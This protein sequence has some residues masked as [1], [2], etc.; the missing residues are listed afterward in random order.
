[1]IELPFCAGFELGSF[2]APS[3]VF[4]QPYAKNRWFG[5]LFMVSSV[6]AFSERIWC[7]GTLI[8]YHMYLFWLTRYDVIAYAT[9]VSI[10]HH[11]TYFLKFIS[12]AIIRYKYV[13]LEPSVK[14]YK[15][16]QCYG[17]LS[18]ISINVS[19]RKTVSLKNFDGYF[20]ILI[21]QKNTVTFDVSNGVNISFVHC[22]L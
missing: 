19:F 9:C 6:N 5:V 14:S 12:C 11:S 13:P 10:W 4:S 17:N 16:N 2:T 20:L 7:T 3:T 1:M 8:T 15:G 22:V 18:I 21:L